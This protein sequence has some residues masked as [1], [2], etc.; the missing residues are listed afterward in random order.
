[1]WLVKGQVRPFLADRSRCHFR[2]IPKWRQAENAED[3]AGGDENE[4]ARH[5]RTEES[6]RGKMKIKGAS[7]P[8]LVIGHF[9]FD[10]IT[11]HTIGPKGQIG[12][13][14]LLTSPPSLTL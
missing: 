12:S 8:F 6:R 2:R 10:L 1:M 3:D 11:L 5:R 7:P 4:E 14:P 13:I 9:P